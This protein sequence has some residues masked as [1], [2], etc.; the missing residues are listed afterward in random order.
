VQSPLPDLGMLAHAHIVHEG[1]AR[2]GHWSHG[3]GL[4]SPAR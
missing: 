2:S 4:R 3:T 1:P